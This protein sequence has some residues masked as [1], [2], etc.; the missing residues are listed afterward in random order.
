MAKKLEPFILQITGKSRIISA[1]FAGYR[2]LDQN[3]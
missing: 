2:G 1:F 3:H